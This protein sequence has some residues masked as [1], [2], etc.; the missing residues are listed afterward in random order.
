MSNFEKY[1]QQK[2]TYGQMFDIAWPNWT[3]F[4]N[5][6]SAYEILMNCT[7]YPAGKNSDI[8]KSLD[9]YYKRSKGDPQLA[10]HMANDDFMEEAGKAQFDTI[11]KT[12]KT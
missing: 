11:E 4:D 5:E 12:S 1:N 10:I 9:S 7:P 8:I 2:M 6:S 3:E